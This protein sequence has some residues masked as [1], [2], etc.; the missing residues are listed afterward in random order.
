MPLPSF[1]ENLRLGTRGS[2]LALIQA[3]EVLLKFQSKYPKINVEIVRIKT[4]G[5]RL[6]GKDL[7]KEGGKG[8]FVKEIEEALLQGAIDIAVHSLK[9]LPGEI[10]EGLELASFPLREDPRESFVS[11]K[12]PSLTALPKGA[13]IGTSSPRRKAQILIWRP[14]CRVAPLH[15]NV[16]TRLQKL[17]HGLYDALILAAAGLKRL[18]REN[19]I[20]RFFETKDFIPA[21]GQGVLGIEIRREDEGLKR[22]LFNSLN[23]EKTAF[24]A[25]AERAFLKAFGGDCYTPLAGY[26]KVEGERIKMVAWVGSPDGKKTLRLERSGEKEKGEILGVALAEELLEQGGREILRCASS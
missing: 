7:A 13:S 16:G 6:Q 3:Y 17:Q 14:D 10:P 18:G 1:P 21:V 9:D 22:L 12:Y 19:D 5:D 11:I 20:T 23:D 25:R 26:A 24:A 15:G 4:S 8:L 2:K